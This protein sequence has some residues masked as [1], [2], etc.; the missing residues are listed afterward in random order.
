MA[1]IVGM[2]AGRPFGQRPENLPCVLCAALCNLCVRSEEGS[3]TEGAG[4]AT[5]LP[6][7]DETGFQRVQKWDACLPYSA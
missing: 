4:L 7:S 2:P 6:T 1:G 3:D 5:A